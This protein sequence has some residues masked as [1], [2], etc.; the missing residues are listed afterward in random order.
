MSQPFPDAEEANQ[1]N[2]A[3]SVP[4]GACNA[5]TASFAALMTQ[6]VEKF[7]K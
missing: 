1:V 5:A 3:I 7:I 6:T 2:D 4:V